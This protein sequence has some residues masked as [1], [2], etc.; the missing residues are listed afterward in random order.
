MKCFLIPLSLLFATTT[1]A[2]AQGVSVAEGTEVLAATVDKL[3]S[4]S[5]AEGDLVSLRVQ[6][7]VV[8]HGVVV[9]AKG[10]AI[11]GAVSNV[12]GKGRMGKSGKISIRIESTTSVDGQKIPLR[13]SKGSEGDGK[14]GTTVALTVLFG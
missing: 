8:V 1:T 14:V 12:E 10:T 3:S 4:K 6:D 11:R 9:I 5:A 2:G 7:D 13:A